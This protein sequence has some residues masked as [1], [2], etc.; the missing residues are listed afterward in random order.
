MLWV[1]TNTYDRWEMKIYKRVLRLHCPKELVRKLTSVKI[2][3]GVDI[4]LRISPIN[5]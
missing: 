5:E 1:G 4:E 3:P 2:D